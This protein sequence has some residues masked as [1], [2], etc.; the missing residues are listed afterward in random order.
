MHLASVLADP[1]TPT[2]SSLLGDV[3]TFLGSALS[4]VGS[5][6]GSITSHPLLLVCVACMPIAGYGVGMLRRLIRS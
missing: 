2:V 4:W 3:T 5:C 1:V 6:I